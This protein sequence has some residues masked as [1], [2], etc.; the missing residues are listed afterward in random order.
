MFKKSDLLVLSIGYPCGNSESSNF[1]KAQVDELKHHFENIYVVAPIA[2][3]PKF[4][5]NCRFISAKHREHSMYEN[6]TYDNVRVFFPRFFSLPMVLFR[7][8]L[9]GY[10]AYQAVLNC[11]KKERISFSFIHAH[12]TWTSG[13]IASKLSE[14]F[15]KKYLVTVHE[16]KIWFREE[17][18]SQSRN[19]YNTWKNAELLIRVNSQDLKLLQEFNPNAIHIPNGFHKHFDNKLT[20]AES[21]MSLNLPQDKKIIVNVANYKIWQKN[22]LN[23]IRSLQILRAQRQDFIC[24]LIGHPH[25]NDE[26][27]L[28]DYIIENGLNEYIIMTGPKLNEEVAVWMKAADLFYFPSLSESFGIVN[29]EALASGTPVVSA[30]NGGSEEIIISDDYGFLARDGNDINELSNLVNAAL[31]KQWDE[32]VLKEYAKTYTLSEIIRK[33]LLEYQ[34]ILSE[35]VSQ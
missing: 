26:Q 4:L 33:L 11:F 30:Y 13:Y 5:R 10:F 16:D 27:I 28:K 19:I 1:V 6:Y 32:Q 8:R 31:E 18:H 14:K 29:I 23:L 9:N 34:K 17:Y 35:K 12:F 3:F 7:K 2:F 21:R 22:Q 24:Y 15:K 20:R 25:G